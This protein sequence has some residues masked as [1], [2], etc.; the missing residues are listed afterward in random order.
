MSSSI[1]SLSYFVPK[2]KTKDWDRA[3][4]T[5]TKLEEVGMQI[6][7][8]AVSST[9]DEQKA[10]RFHI[11]HWKYWS[12]LVAVGSRGTSYQ[13]NNPT[14]F[15]VKWDVVV[16]LF[17][18]REL[19]EAEKEEQAAREA[20]PPPPKV[21]TQPIDVPDLWPTNDLQTWEEATTEAVPPAA[22]VAA[23]ASF[24]PAGDD[25]ASQVQDEWNANATAQQSSWGG[26]CAD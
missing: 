26:G 19:E 7:I 25:W 4:A 14:G 23:P 15:Q 5:K 17:F 12:N 2:T 8:S 9:S 16:D 11:V 3:D 13:G 18:F 21:E 6:Y 1:R 22:A 24:V 20:L 10:N